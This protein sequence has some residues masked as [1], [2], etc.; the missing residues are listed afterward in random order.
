MA[1]IIA[2]AA[3]IAGGCQ[4]VPNRPEAVLDLYRERMRSQN[5]AEARKLLSEDSQKIVQEITTNYRL[6]QPPEDLALLNA[7]DPASAPVPMKSEAT[8]ALLQVRTLKGGLR[9]IR[10]TRKDP[11][12]PWTIDLTEELRALETFLKGRSALEEM[13]DQASEYAASWKAFN[14]QL[15]KMHIA[16]PPAPP[17]PI[18]PKPPAP[19]PKAKHKAKTETK[20]NEQKK[21]FTE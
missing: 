14:R 17:K 2:V 1:A 9:L 21:T 4:L 11:N 3:A 10:L 8:T 20:R 5:L 19:K 13:R 6:Q 15:D 16:E 12:S 18:H 7:L